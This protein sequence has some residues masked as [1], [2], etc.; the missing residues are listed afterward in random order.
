MSLS[1]DVARCAGWEN[2]LKSEPAPTC[3]DCLRRTEPGHPQRQAH[4]MP[5]RFEQGVCP[6]R[7][8]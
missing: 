5:P 6:E 1:Y 8:T 4:I 7:R 3:A 2:W